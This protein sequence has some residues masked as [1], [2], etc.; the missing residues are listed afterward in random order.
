[1]PY[2]DGLLILNPLLI[3][4]VIKSWGKLELHSLVSAISVG[5]LG[6]ATNN[7][8]EQ[9]WNPSHGLPRQM[10]GFLGS[11]WAESDRLSVSRLPD[12]FGQ[13]VPTD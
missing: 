9:V 8:N 5:G 2:D 10:Q 12:M 6:R 7:E 13:H 11:R 1:M 4:M 3:K